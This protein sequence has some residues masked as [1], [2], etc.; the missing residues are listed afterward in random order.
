MLEI[1]DTQTATA[2]LDH[3]DF[4]SFRLKALLLLGLKALYPSR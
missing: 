4:R 1:L 2:T 3:W